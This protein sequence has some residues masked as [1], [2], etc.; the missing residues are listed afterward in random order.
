MDM[1]SDYHKMGR[2]IAADADAS[3]TF[4]KAWASV[5]KELGHEPA[6]DSELAQ[7]TKRAIDTFGKERAANL[8]GKGFVSL[9]FGSEATRPEDQEAAK[10]FDN[11]DTSERL[12]VVEQVY[13]SDALADFGQIV[14]AVANSDATFADMPQS[15]PTVPDEAVE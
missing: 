8:S 9:A 12:Q 4:T 1:N 7:V 11:M 6:S 3:E 2:E 5:Q 14:D 13:N 10:V 15:K